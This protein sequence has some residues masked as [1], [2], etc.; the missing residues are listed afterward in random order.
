MTGG[1]VARLQV[2]RLGERPHRDQRDRTNANHIVSF[3]RNL[4]VEPRSLCM[5]FRYRTALPGSEAMAS[6]QHYDE[7]GR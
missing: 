3:R 1:P 2:G 6:L 5:A 4:P 7:A